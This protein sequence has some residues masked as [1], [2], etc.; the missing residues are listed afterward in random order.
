[1]TEAL[2]ATGEQEQALQMIEL[3]KG[4]KSRR[5]PDNYILFFLLDLFFLAMFHVFRLQGFNRTTGH[6]RFAVR[7]PAFCS[8]D[9]LC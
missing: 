6:R 9:M 1:M 3:H 8:G 5:D 7:V 2:L 4:S